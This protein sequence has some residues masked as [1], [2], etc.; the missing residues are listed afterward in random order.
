MFLTSI[1]VYPILL[2]SVL[3]YFVYLLLFIVMF[4]VVDDVHFVNIV[5]SFLLSSKSSI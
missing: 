4:I 2:C 3:F 5:I 1:L